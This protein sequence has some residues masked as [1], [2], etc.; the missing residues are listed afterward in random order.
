[1]GPDDPDAT[2]AIYET[3]ARTP[4]RHLIEQGAFVYYLGMIYPFMREL[5]HVRG[6]RR[7]VASAWEFDREDGDVYYKL[8]VDEFARVTVPTK[9]FDPKDSAFA[10]VPPDTKF[11][12]RT[13]P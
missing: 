6:V 12:E 13:T 10:L 5:G 7:G 4:R 8:D 9:L 3:F 11:K 1:M 2:L